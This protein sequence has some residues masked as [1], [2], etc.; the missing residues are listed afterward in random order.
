M[1]VPG[2]KLRLEGSTN[3]RRELRYDAATGRVTSH[4]GSPRPPYQTVAQEAAVF[5]RQIAQGC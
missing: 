2:H 1:T 4:K 5:A 3:P